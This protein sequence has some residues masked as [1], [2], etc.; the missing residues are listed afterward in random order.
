MELAMQ[1]PGRVR[2]VVQAGVMIFADTERAELLANYTPSIA[3]RWDGSHL[4][5]AWA[6]VRD[7][8]PFGGAFVAGFALGFKM[9]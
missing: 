2:H 1:R 8:L 6:I 4:V 9:G 3:P 5:T 7:Q